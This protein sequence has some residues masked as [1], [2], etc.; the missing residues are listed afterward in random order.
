MTFDDLELPFRTLLQNTYVF[1]AHQENFNADPYYQRHRCSAMTS[2]WRYKIYADIR[3][4]SV[5]TR[6]QTTVG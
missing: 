2:L 6:R 3:G 1:G 5:E 4:G